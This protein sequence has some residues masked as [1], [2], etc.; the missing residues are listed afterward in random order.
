MAWRYQWVQI[1]KAPLSLAKESGKDQSSRA[2]KHLDNNFYTSPTTTT[3]R[4]G[5]VRET[6]IPPGTP[7]ILS[8]SLNSH[9]HPPPL[10]VN[11][12]KIKN[13]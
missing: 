5:W 11:G 8:A 10:D 7:P 2:E 9:F 4:K 13:L 12:G 3:S 6:F 1:Q